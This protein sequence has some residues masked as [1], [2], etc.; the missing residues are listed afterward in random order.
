MDE[1][2]C[3]FGKIFGSVRK[4]VRAIAERYT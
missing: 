3:I 1:H 2:H 4:L